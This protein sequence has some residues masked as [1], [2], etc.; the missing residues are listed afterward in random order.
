MTL[1]I[2]LT[3]LLLAALL[4]VVWPLYR[5]AGRLTGLLAGVVAVTVLLSAGLYYQIGEPDVPSG[6]GTM[7]DVN[8]MVSSLAARLE[9]NPNDAEGWTMLGRS[10]ATM[11]RFPESVRAYEKAL[12]LQD[13]SNPQTMVALAVVLIESQGG[14]ISERASDLLEDSLAL[15]PNNPNALFYSGFA[16]ANRGETDVAADRWESL[17]AQDAPPEIRD[18]LQQKVNEWRGVEPPA[19]TAIE[20]PGAIVNVAV[21]VSTDAAAALPVDAAVFIIAR[22]PAQPSPPIAVT[23]RRLSELPATISLGDRDSM[24]PGR[25]LSGFDNFELLARVSLSGAPIAQQGDWF[26]SMLVDTGDT[27]DVAL[28]IDTQVR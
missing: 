27:A 15:D 3:V 25:S 19:R 16:A 20:Q 1:W 17:L 21:S 13:G 12:Q 11:K 23:R 24:V 7:P 8:E 10:Y 4:F 5:E 9:E 2:S 18:L 22:D 14:G 6:A 26:G 28:T